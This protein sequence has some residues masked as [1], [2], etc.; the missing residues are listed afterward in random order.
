[1]S[2][3]WYL[4]LIYIRPSAFVNICVAKSGKETTE[5]KENVRN[6]DSD[7][8]RKIRKSHFKNF[9][10]I[11]VLSGSGFLVADAINT[12]CTLELF[13]IRVFRLVSII[14]VAWT[15]L[16]KLTWEIQ[17]WSGESLPEKV[18]SFAFK[19]FYGV[20]IFMAVVAIFLEVKHVSA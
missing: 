4:F 2:K 1:M 7:R 15:V 11:T 13:S 18:N 12:Y 8:T 16:S 17:S 20:G 19:F 9:V 3:L 14:I 10:L 6:N 5:D